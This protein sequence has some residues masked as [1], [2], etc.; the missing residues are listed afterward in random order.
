M[1]LLQ[2]QAPLGG[3]ERRHGALRLAEVDIGRIT[4]IAPYPGEEINCSHSLQSALSLSFPAP[5]ETRNSLAGRILWTGRSQA[6]LLGPQ[7]PAALSGIAA[8]IDQSDAWAA[9]TLEGEGAVETLQRLV[10]LDL[11]PSVFPIWRTAR[12]LLGHM[13]AQITPTETGFELLVMRSMARTAAH[14][15]EEAMKSVAARVQ[16]GE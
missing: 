5:G 1:K 15:I 11:R 9:L 8:V 10:P 2:A 16:I 3:F 12:S 4:W 14:E 13:N 6:L 7:P